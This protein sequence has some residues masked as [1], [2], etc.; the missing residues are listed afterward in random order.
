MRLAKTDDV[1]AFTHKHLNNPKIYPYLSTST[2][3]SFRDLRSD[4]WAGL[5]FVSEDLNCMLEVNFDRSRGMEFSVCLFSTTPFKAGKA[6]L[7]VKDL[8]K[9]Y[10][11]RAINSVVHH[12]NELSLRLHRK[13]FGDPWGTEEKYAWN[14]LR[15]EYEDLHYFRK[16]L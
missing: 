11:P 4:D 8:I 2:T 16:L 14:S 9:R 13:F 6:I 3:F 5:C 7:I 1:V 12:S 15:G 10:N